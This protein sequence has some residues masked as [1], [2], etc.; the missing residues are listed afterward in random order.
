M[1]DNRKESKENQ[2]RWIFRDSMVE[3]LIEA[4]EASKTEYEGR[5]LDFEG[6]LVKLYSELR[7]TMSEK[8]EETDFGPAAVSKPTKSIEEMS[9]EEF[10]EQKKNADGQQKAIKL[11]Y[12]RIK[13]K[14][15]K[16]RSNFQK[17][18]A[19]GTRSGSRRI[20]KDNWDAL[21]RIWGG[22]PGAQPLEFGKSSIEDTDKSHS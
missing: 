4:L 5:G 11:G 22:A 13:A 2:T 16:L 12:D 3:D 17:A 8:Y 15:K 21:V 6:D 7:R 10:K 19:E 1:A 18:V 9:K 20:I 14:V